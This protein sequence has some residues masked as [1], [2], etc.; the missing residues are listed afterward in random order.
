MHALRE[1]VACLVIACT[2]MIVYAYMYTVRKASW[3]QAGVEPVHWKQAHIETRS[4]VGGKNQEW[5]LVLS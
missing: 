3:N 1:C 5:T 4:R 2:C